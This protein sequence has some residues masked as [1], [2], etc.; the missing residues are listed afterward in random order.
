MHSMS[1]YPFGK[2]NFK[3]ATLLPILL[4]SMFTMVPAMSSRVA[5]NIGKISPI[6]LNELA[7]AGESVNV[8]IK[9]F[10]N[11]YS[12]LVKQINDLGGEIGY[13]FKYVNALS[14][15]LQ[16]STI[17]E[18]T[19]SS[20]VERIYYDTPMELSS[21]SDFGDLLAE[22]E[23]MEEEVETEAF[24][25]EE[26]SSV[27]PNSYWNTIGMGAQDI[28]PQTNYGAGSLAVIIDTGIWLNHFMFA[29]KVLLNEIAGGVDVSRDNFAVYQQ[30]PPSWPYDPKYFGWD[31]A[32]NHYHG[33]HCAGILAS[34]GGVIAVPGT[35][36][37]I[38]A[39]AL[40][41]YSGI[42]LPP[43]PTPGSKI[44]WTLGM[45]PAAT[46]YIVK[47]FDHTGGS[48]P[49]AIVL[50]G[51][52][53]ALDLKLDQGYD[54][55]VIS[56]S[57]G[58][59]SLFDGRDIQ[60]TL[61]NTITANGITLVAAAGNYGPASNTVSRPGSA[62][63]AITAGWA[64]NPVNTKAFWDYSY[65][66]QGRGSLMF[67][68]PTPQIYAG[69]SRGPTSDGRVKPTLA[70]TGQHVYS[71]YITGGATGMAWASGTSMATPAIAG[72]TSLLNAYSEMNNLGASPEDYKQ[73]LTGGAVWLPG[74]GVYDQGAGYLNAAYALRVLEAD[75][76][77]G[78]VAPPLPEEAS[79]VD[80]S[81]IP[82]TIHGVYT[83]SIINLP[84]GRKQEYIFH[85]GEATDSI[86]LD[87][88][89]VV[90]GNNPLGLNSFE[91]Y[92]QGAKRT[93]SDYYVSGANVKGNS[94]FYITDDAITWSTPPFP[95]EPTFG[96]SI[97][98]IEPGYIKVVIEN[99]WTSY[100]SAS[101]DIT[102]TVTKAKKT[103]ATVTYSGLIWPEQIIGWIPVNVPSGT[104]KAIV[105]LW[106][107][108]N[109]NTYPSADLDLY[110]FWNGA[111][112]LRAATS[113]SPE[114]AILIGP[115]GTILFQ[116]EG[117]LIYTGRE[118]FEL[119][120]T[121]V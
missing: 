23:A 30:Y 37:Y 48:I 115:T 32:L 57:I 92:I 68:S 77:Y 22:P 12:D 25:P 13:L 21:G 10:S 93:R 112:D 7:N 15:S 98:P 24:T 34:R 108:H 56:M 81:N 43:G 6:L 86:R 11:D 53:H 73:A 26:M 9:T 109:W 44:I 45:A 83:T 105:E 101:A 88:T 110:I 65:Q 71:A 31:N 38:Y 107:T 116:I 120:I 102:I 78:D 14:A 4:L 49:T 54:V 119:R 60:D 106:W 59:T 103:P 61:V 35:P 41:M 52:E 28:W 67:T 82:I 55:D 8:L 1:S 19:R 94:Y 117:Y 2:M 113:N 36:R 51:M 42:P 91:V 96:R 69:S 85:A 16:P 97:H 80:L 63:T 39:Q 66:V 75:T 17:V 76:S 50:S 114:R 118:P 29:P 33:G 70:A 89:N 5:P 84:P 18:L 100:D 47:V 20:L 46:L 90:L 87:V 58:G 72:A 3:A 79:L 104:T 40:E 121:F 27:D 99:D 95:P 74:Y 111:M 62:Y 64:A